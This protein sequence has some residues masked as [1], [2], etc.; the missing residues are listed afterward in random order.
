MLTI[1]PALIILD[2]TSFFVYNILIFFHIIYILLFLFHYLSS[3][4]FAD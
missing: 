2:E 1:I 3:N 4:S